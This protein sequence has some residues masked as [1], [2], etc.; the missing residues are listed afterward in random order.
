MEMFYWVLNCRCKCF[1]YLLKN[2]HYTFKNVQI[3]F[4]LK[5][6]FTC[7]TCNLIYVTIC[8]TCKE[9]YIGGTGEE[10]NKLRGRVRVYH[11]HIR[12]PHYKQLKVEVHLRVCGNGKF[13]IFLLLHMRSQDT[14]HKNTKAKLWN[15][16]PA[17]IQNKIK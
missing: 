1:N 5:I 12:Q 13:R 16:V 9:K 10:R 2:Y 8:D 3:T 7:D 6:C 11:Q 15:V 17:K 4:K 14:R